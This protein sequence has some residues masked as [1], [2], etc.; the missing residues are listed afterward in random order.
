M[1]EPGDVALTP[2]QHA[3]LV[4]LRLRD[5]TKLGEQAMTG[6]GSEQPIERSSFLRVRLAIQLY[7]RDG[8]LSVHQILGSSSRSDS[9]RI[10]E[11]SSLPERLLREDARATACSFG[12]GF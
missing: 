2:P 7:R 5:A 6:I 9:S 3:L 10:R 12:T 1:D 11:A 4:R 8:E